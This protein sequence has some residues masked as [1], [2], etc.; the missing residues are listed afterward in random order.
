MMKKLIFIFVLLFTGSVIC[1]R[2][3][4]VDTDTIPLSLKESL[5]ILQA[6]DKA[7]LPELQLLQTALAGFEKVAEEQTINHP[8]VITII[9]F[10]LPSDKERLWV[11]DLV[12]AKVLFH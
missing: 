12:H 1:P 6:G 10:S 8:E 4:A 9:D 7:K 5:M 11:I 3:V 2:G